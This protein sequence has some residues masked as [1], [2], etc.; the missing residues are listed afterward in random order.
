MDK[1]PRRTIRSYGFLEANSFYSLPQTY[2]EARGSILFAGER[3][4]QVCPKGSA[5]SFSNV[6]LLNNGMAIDVLA[7]NRILHIDREKEE[8]CVQAG[9]LVP[10]ILQQIMP[11]GFTLVG[12]TGSLGNTVAGNIGND[13]NGKDSWKNG[14]FCQNV[15]S[16][17]IITAEGILLDITPISHPELFAAI[18]GG[19]GLIALVVEVTL[20]MKRIPSFMVQEE[21]LKLSGLSDLTHQMDQ[22]DGTNAEFA[23]CWTDPYAPLAQLGRG[24]IQIAHFVKDPTDHPTEKLQKGFVQ[25]KRIGPFT[26][27]IFWG[28]ARQFDAPFMYGIAGYLKYHLNY[29]KSFRPVPFTGYQYPMLKYLPEWNLKYYPYSFREIQI[30]FPTQMFHE[31]FEKIMRICRAKKFIPYVCAVRKHKVQPGYLSF[32]ENG[33]SMTLN[34]GLNDHSPKETTIFEE[35]VIETILQLGGRIYLGKYPFL[36]PETVKRMYPGMENFLRIKREIDPKNI[37]WSDAADF[38]IGH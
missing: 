11:M 36:S 5:L 21:R 38:L 24:F 7:L 19:M 4:L 27:K 26:P 8:I 33:F 23:Y 13:V 6:C 2:E 22:L 32:A 18:A 35:T 17:K 37:F 34:Y 1:Y 14:H 3:Q 15:L 12:L 25:K 9:T 20:K 29:S 31:G 10:H 30:L 28:I 16:L